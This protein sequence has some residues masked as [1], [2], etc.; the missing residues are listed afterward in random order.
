ME[1]VILCTCLLHRYSSL[2][3][4]LPFSFLDHFIICISLFLSFKDRL[5]Y[6]DTMEKVKTDS[7]KDLSSRQWENIDDSFCSVCV[8]VQKVLLF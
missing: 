6:H 2:S 1:L 7:I 8:K 3:Y 5:Q 4:D